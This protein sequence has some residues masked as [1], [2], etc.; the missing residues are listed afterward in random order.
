MIVMVMIL[1]Y[2]LYLVKPNIRWRFL[3]LKIDSRIKERVTLNVD[4][5]SKKSLIP[6]DVGHSMH[7]FLFAYLS[8]PPAAELE[9]SLVLPNGRKRRLF[10]NDKR[11]TLVA[12]VSSHMDY[13]FVVEKTLSKKTNMIKL[14]I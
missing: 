13:N 8:D 12:A 3:N 4:V 6:L 11:R 1:K 14:Y 9:A 2:H 7:H 10:L 5:V